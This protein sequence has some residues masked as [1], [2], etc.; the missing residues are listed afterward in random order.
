MKSK[1]CVTLY[2]KRKQRTAQ[3]KVGKTAYIVTPIHKKSGE[4]L[5]EILIK[6]MRQDAEKP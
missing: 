1:I 6:L 2:R 3:Y 4:N 5:K